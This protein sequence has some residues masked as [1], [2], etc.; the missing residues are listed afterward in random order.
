MSTIV[1]TG[2]FIARLRPHAD[3]PLIFEYDDRRVQT[4]YHVTEI[5]AA[6]VRS[7]DCGANPEQWDETI[8]QLW[9][10]PGEAG[11]G[12]M[13]VGKFLAIY[14]KVAARVSLDAGASL[15][16]EWGD[17]VSPAIR[18]TA[19]SLSIGQ[20]A[21]VVGLEPVRAS[22]KPRDRWS[23]PRAATPPVLVPASPVNPVGPTASQVAGGCCSATPAAMASGTRAP[24]AGCGC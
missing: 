20:E 24:A 8:V 15:K 10:V 21:V 2:D 12:F 7:V 23:E 13:T 9:D 17:V 14:D 19:D 5:M 22:C 16:F 4:G 3:K 11:E 1:S 18:L 6:S